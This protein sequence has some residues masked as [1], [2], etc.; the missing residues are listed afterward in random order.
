MSTVSTPKKTRNNSNFITILRE[1]YNDLIALKKIIPALKQKIIS[2]KDILRWSREAR[3]LRKKRK[4][5]LLRSLRD[6]R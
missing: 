1:E 2:E 5:P 6:L 3:T 4:L